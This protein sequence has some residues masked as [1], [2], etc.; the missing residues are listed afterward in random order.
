VSELI[1]DSIET[2]CSLMAELSPSILRE[3]LLPALQ[4]L[5]LWMRERHGLTV[6]LAGE[7][8]DGEA[9]V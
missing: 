4:W 2:A 6:G 8:S 3:G 7:A 9:A 1:D 5:A